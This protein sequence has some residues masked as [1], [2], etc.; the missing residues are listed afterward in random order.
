MQVLPFRQDQHPVVAGHLN[1]LRLPR[2][3]GL[4][5]LTHVKIFAPCSYEVFQDRTLRIEE[6]PDVPF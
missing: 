5:A 3:L 2:Y 6:F 1:H 4:N